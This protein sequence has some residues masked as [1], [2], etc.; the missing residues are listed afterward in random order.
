MYQRLKD[1]SDPMEDW[2]TLWQTSCISMQT[3]ADF[4]CFGFNVATYPRPKKAI[5][6][7][8]IAH[9]QYIQKSSPSTKIKQIQGTMYNIPLIQ[10]INCI[11]LF[12]YIKSILRIF[13]NLIT[14]RKLIK[15][16]AL[17]LN[18]HEL[19]CHVPYLCF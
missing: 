2:H 14:F 18:L 17:I 16:D 10:S 6:K 15:P 11:F 9:I 12:E 3:S 19:Y 4:S 8:N 7:A 5:L 1:L 13:S